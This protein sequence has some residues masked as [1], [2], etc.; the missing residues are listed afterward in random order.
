MSWIL[1]AL[2]FENKDRDQQ[3]KA[4]VEK[5]RGFTVTMLFWLIHVLYFSALKEW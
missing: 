1:K 4:K 2:N 5:K 3:K